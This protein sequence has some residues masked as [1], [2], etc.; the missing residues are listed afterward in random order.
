[1]WTTVLLLARPALAA[2]AYV[3][4]GSGATL[5][6]ACTAGQA[7][8]LTGSTNQLTLTGDC[9]VLTISGSNN[10]VTADGLSKLTITGSTNSVTYSRNLSSKKKLPSTITGIGNSV[11]KK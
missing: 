11:V 5:T 8:N 1:M 2:D 6:H 7:V 9:G 3:V 10:Q 4:D